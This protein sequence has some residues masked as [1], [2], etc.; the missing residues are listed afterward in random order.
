MST[1]KKE[2][3]KLAKAQV[4]I[5]K[6]E[7][8][9]KKKQIKEESKNYKTLIDM[10]NLPQGITININDKNKTNDLVVTGLTPDQMKRILPR[11]NKDLLITFTEESN[12]FRASLL[13]FLREGLFHTI[14]K[15]IA[16]LIVGYLLVY[17]GLR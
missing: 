6:A 1:S 15:V 12:P 3:K 2:Q 17:I 14:I 8:K 13:R 10:K 9:V 4:K 16:G 7:A 11:L 5:A